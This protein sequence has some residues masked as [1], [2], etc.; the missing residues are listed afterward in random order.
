[1]FVIM[2]KQLCLSLS[3]FLFMQ[4]L[5][6]QPIL[7]GAY[8]TQEYLPI[9]KQKRVGIFANHTT[10]INKT[11]VV[12]SL[13]N[14]GVTITKIFAP[15]HGFRGKADAGE[16]VNSYIDSTTKIPVISLYGSK[17]KPSEKDVEDVDILVFDVQDVGVRFYT[18][19]SSLQEFIEAAIEL[20]KPLIVFDR[21]NPNGFYVD[22]PVLDTAY[23]S[24][25]GM[26]P[27][28]VV[29]GM[30]MGEYAKM[31]IGEKWLSKRATKQTDNLVSL[32][33][34]LGFEQERK[35][36]YL[37]IINCKNYTH[38]SKYQLPVAPSP[39]LATMAA[40]YWY[41][42]TC[43][44]E[45]T[46][47]SE[48]RGTDYP[49]CIFGH[50]SFKAYSDTAV[51]LFKFTPIARFGAKEPKLKNQVCYGWNLYNPNNKQ[52]LKSIN[53]KI[54][55]QYLI[56]AYR[57]FSLYNNADSFFIHPKNR[58]DKNYFFNKLVGDGSL[59][60]QLYL[61]K[62]EIQ[63]RKS[64]QPALQKFKVIRKKYLLYKDF[65]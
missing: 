4:I 26:Q 41:P 6:A 20:N 30:T 54:Q 48:G 33:E 44:F 12:D 17:R 58:I 52:I 13:Q 24:F 61:G 47:L 42:S 27:I 63:I 2:K 19:I 64:W 62:D 34:M 38:K 65:E 9:L 8:Q 32:G 21:P 10:I 40:I 55:L 31:L 25:V 16:H 51:N 37:K 60:Q 53:N 1:M 5:Q 3:F 14:L 45:G 29:Y 15:E 36:F 28:P 49:F 11:H 56:K 46:V 57:L 43:Y 35:D 23:R 59:K 39:N 50:P 22:G 18:Y 7:P